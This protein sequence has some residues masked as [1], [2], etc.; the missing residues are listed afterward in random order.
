MQMGGML[1]KLAKEFTV[2]L[3]N[4]LALSALAFTGSY[5]F[6]GDYHLSITVCMAL[7]T[8]IIVAAVLGTFVPLMLDK[9][10]IDPALATG[11]F[12]T[13]LNDIIGLFIYFVV[14]QL[15]YSFL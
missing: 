14:G 5:L 2:A 12:V 7:M 4:G 1:S 8:V 15:V 13:T 9:Y 10:K 3:V 6:F 11:P